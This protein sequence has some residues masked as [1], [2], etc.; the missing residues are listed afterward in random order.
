MSTLQNGRA[1]IALELDEDGT[2]RDEIRREFCRGQKDSDGPFAGVVEHLRAYS[3]RRLASWGTS[4]TR[5]IQGVT[6][7]SRFLLLSNVT[8]AWRDASAPAE[9]QTLQL[10]NRSHVGKRE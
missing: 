5:R 2:L 4:V 1:Q 10:T 8:S 6:L 3:T 9:G 7:M